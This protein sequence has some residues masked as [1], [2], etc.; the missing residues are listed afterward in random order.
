VQVN[1][2]KGILNERACRVP[3]IDVAVLH[4]WI[5]HLENKPEYAIFTFPITAIGV[6]K[7]DI[8]IFTDL[9]IRVGLMENILVHFQD[10]PISAESIEGA[11]QALL[12]IM[13]IGYW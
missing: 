12:F 2:L 3:L 13:D 11:L 1:I 5:V 8:L 9:G 10:R 6:L 7:Q 4:W